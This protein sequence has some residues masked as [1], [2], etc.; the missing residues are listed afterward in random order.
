MWKI[1]T[2]FIGLALAGLLHPAPA[3]ANP[4]GNDPRVGC[5]DIGHP[6]LLN[7][8]GRRTICDGPRLADGSWQRL[9]IIYTPAHHVNASSYCGT[10]TCSFDAGGDYAM[11]IQEKR[12]YAVSD[13][14]GAE[15]APL[16]D[17]PGWLPPGT[18]NIG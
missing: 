18:D 1:A 15:N 2:T 7:W 8:I 4:F 13:A 10:Y 17:E 12:Q 3:N 9:R 11:T 5:E 16:P 6:S 14:P